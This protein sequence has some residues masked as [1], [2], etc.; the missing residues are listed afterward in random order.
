MQD[1]KQNEK[2]PSGW[3]KSVKTQ[4]SMQG[5]TI[6]ECIPVAQQLPEG[7]STHKAIHLPCITF[8]LTGGH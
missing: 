1:V 5:L 6:S 7:L 2:Y 3:N 4:G 8:N